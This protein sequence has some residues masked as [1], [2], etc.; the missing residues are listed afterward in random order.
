MEDVMAFQPSI[1]RRSRVHLKHVA[2]VWD[3]ISE[4][5]FLESVEIAEFEEALHDQSAFAVVL[6]SAHQVGQAVARATD[7]E[8]LEEV[9]QTHA[10][11]LQMLPPA[12]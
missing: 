11:A 2:E 10:M 3:R 5:R 9:W 8:R 4:D 1:A 6:D 12:A 7:D